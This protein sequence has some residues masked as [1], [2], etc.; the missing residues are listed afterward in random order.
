MPGHNFIDFTVIVM[1]VLLIWIVLS[2][3]KKMKKSQNKKSWFSRFGNSILV[4][5]LLLILSGLAVLVLFMISFLFEKRTQNIYLNT[6]ACISVFFV[7]FYLSK[8]ITPEENSRTSKSFIIIGA[9]VN[10]LVLTIFFVI[11]EKYQLPLK[12]FF[13]NAL[14]GTLELALYWNFMWVLERYVF[15]KTEKRKIKRI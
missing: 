11:K 1:M 15:H 10:A 6:Y 7:A 8:M 5:R 14:L 12:G 3:N 13:F 9:I 4:D 2:K